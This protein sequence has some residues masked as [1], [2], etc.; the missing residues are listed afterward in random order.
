MW[1][2]LVRIGTFEISSFGAMMFLVDRLSER[3]LAG[4]E[5]K[6]ILP[7]ANRGRLQA[8]HPADHDGAASGLAGSHQY[9]GVGAK[10]RGAAS[11]STLRP[12]D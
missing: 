7:V 10:D 5:E 2:T 3:G 11:S 4:L 1:P 12:I 9:G 8:E 6:G